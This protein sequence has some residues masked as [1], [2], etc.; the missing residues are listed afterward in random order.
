M[1]FKKWDEGYLF[2]TTA[3]RMKADWKTEREKLIEMVEEL[4]KAVASD[5]YKIVGK[6]QNG[7]PLNAT[8]KARMRASIILAE[9]KEKP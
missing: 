5:P 8:G 1:T 9:V 3:L 7:H 2:D 4:Y 6:D